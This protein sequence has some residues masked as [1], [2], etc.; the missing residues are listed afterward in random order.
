LHI[1]FPPDG[2]RLDLST[3]AG[4]TDPIP[5]KISGANGPITVLINGIPSPPQARGTLFFT[6][7]GPGFS[8]VTVIDSTG[9]MDSIL[10]R[11]D[12]GT[13]TKLSLRAVQ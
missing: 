2:S 5:L 10:V 1:L 4:K 9:S 13:S 11:I 8:R 6:P 12:D 7:E 3:T